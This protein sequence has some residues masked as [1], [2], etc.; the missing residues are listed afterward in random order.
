MTLHTIFQENIKPKYKC[1]TWHIFYK[2][3]KYA[4]AFSLILFIAHIFILF[5]IQKCRNIIIIKIRVV[6]FSAILFAHAGSSRS[7]RRRN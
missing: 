1:S 5:T 2:N 6:Y 7:E 4:P 3:G